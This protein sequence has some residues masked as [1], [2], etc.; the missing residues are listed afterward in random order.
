MRI[1][2]SRRGLPRSVVSKVPTSS[3][4]IGEL[5]AIG[6]GCRRAVAPRLPGRRPIGS[7]ERGAAKTSV[8]AALPE[9]SPR[10]RGI[11]GIKTSGPH[12]NR[13]PLDSDAEPSELFG[14]AAATLVF[15]RG[16]AR[17]TRSG[18]RPGAAARRLGAS[19][20]Y[21]VEFSYPLPKLVGDLETTSAVI[22]ASRPRSRITS[23]TRASPAQVP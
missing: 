23:G 11:H 17:R 8:A 13:R 10:R 21:R 22:P 14:Q 6:R 18:L 19:P 5:D 15:R 1:S 3:P 4:R 20:P 2:A 7:A 9:K 16:L 12:G